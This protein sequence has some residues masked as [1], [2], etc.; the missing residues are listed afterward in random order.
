MLSIAA[1]QSKVFISALFI[2]VL[3]ALTS[4]TLQAEESAETLKINDTDFTCMLD[5]TP[6]RGFYVDNLIEGQLDKTIAVAT[7]ESGDYPA[8]SVVQLVPT[9]VMVKHPKGFNAATKDWEFFELNVSAQGS[10]IHKRGFVDVVNRFGGNCFGCHVK[11]KPQFDMICE[12][13]HGC[14]PIPLTAQITQLL[15]KTD[16]RCGG[17]YTPTAQEIEQLKQLRASLSANG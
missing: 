9:E 3:L 16:A 12:T 2:S 8:G 6:V 14:D 13:G 15:Q 1:P 4:L 5:M 10:A 17:R 11:A 7:A